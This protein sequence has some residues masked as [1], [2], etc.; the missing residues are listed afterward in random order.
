MQKRLV[1]QHSCN[2]IFS[3][4]ITSFEEFSIS[5]QCTK[6]GEKVWLR[7]LLEKMTGNP[8]SLSS[9]LLPR[10]HCVFCNYV[11]SFFKPTSI[12]VFWLQSSP[13]TPSGISSTFPCVIQC[14]CKRLGCVHGSLCS[15]NLNSHFDMII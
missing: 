1:F 13:K 6:L 4:T 9:N 15:R 5:T 14:L 3:F 11:E 12:R 2:R 10:H 8:S 7:N